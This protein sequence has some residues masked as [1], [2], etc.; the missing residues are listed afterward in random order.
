MRPLLTPSDLEELC[1]APVAL[2]FKHSDRCP[3]SLSAL[4]EVEELE[5]RRPDLAIG[6]VDVIGRRSLSL[7]AA[8]RFGVR[9]QSPQV[10]LLVHGDV[11]WDASHFSVRAS[12]IER[13]LALLEADAA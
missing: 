5:R 2:V 3:I 11:A 1:R 9:H 13:R 4:D 6:L 10:L 12:A 7:A 8:D